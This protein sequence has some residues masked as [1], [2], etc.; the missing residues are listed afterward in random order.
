MG[1]L[2]VGCRVVDEAEAADF[3]DEEGDGEDGHDRD[4]FEG[5]LDLE[6]HLVLEVFGVL[7]SGLVEDKDVAEG[8]ESCV[9]E[10][11]EE[12]G[13]LLVHCG[14][15]MYRERCRDLPCEDVQADSLPPNIVP[16]PP[17]HVRVLARLDAHILA[18]RLELPCAAQHV[19]A[20]SGAVEGCIVI[21][22]LEAGCDGANGVE[23]GEC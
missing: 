20:L 8:C 23:G 12:P 11:A 5:L 4:G 17:A 1:E 6:T 13:K 21:Q 3:G 2:G 19:N 7:E 18:R 16:V 10:S 22:A 15:I 14:G 9:N